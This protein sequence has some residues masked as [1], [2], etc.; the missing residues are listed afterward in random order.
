MIKRFIKSLISL[1]PTKNM[2]VFESI[3]NLSDNPKPVFDEMVRRGLNEKYR[4]VWIVSHKSAAL[5]AIKNVIYCDRTAKGY[6]WRL[7]YYR[8]FAKVLFSCNDFLPTLRK[9]QLSFYITHG[10]GIKSV[11]NYYNVPPHMDYILVDGEGT[12]EMTAYQ[13]RGDVEK[14][15][16]LGYPRND[17]LV[18]A[19]R[20][21]GRLFPENAGNKIVVWYPTFRQHKNGEQNAT[22]AAL[23]LL[24]DVEQA[25]KLNAIAK[26]N[27]VLIVLKPHFAQDVRRIKAC[28][29]SHIRFIDD[30]FFVQNQITS[31]EFI[32]GCD[33]LLTDYSSVYYDYLLCDKPIGLVWEDY[34]EYKKNVDFVLDMDYY[35]KAGEKI[36]NLADLETFL[37]NLAA[38]K[39]PL[40]VQRAEISAWANYARDGRSAQRVTDFIVEKANLKF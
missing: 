19:K 27:G 29:L 1:I 26:Q 28:N 35:M 31:Y 13:L 5:P 21:I 30:D 23:P 4:M 14:T 37:K 20:E 15:V 32:A 16:A 9:G 17:V 18:H 12:R 25:E 33:A 10:T 36:Y 40:K 7:L 11:R 22:A 38:G 24:H 39:D 8:V 2:I 6:R 34:A 3:P